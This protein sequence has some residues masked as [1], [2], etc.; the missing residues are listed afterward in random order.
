MSKIIYLTTQL[1]PIINVGMYETNLDPRYL[2]SS[3][4]D[5]LED[6]NL[7]EV[8]FDFPSYKNDIVSAANSILS[9]INDFKK[10]GVLSIKMTKIESPKEYNFSND[11]GVLEV[12]L[13]N[14]FDQQMRKNINIKRAKSNEPWEQ[15]MNIAIQKIWGSR[16]GF[17]SFMPSSIEEIYS[18]SIDDYERA[19]A[20]YLQIMLWEDN[21]EGGIIPP[22]DFHGNRQED[23]N[24]IQMQLIGYC[25]ENLYYSE[26]ATTEHIYSEELWEISQNT[27]NNL[28]TLIWDLFDAGIIKHN[29]IPK[30]ED[31]HIAFLKWCKENE[32]ETEEQLRNLIKEQAA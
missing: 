9:K 2:F 25:E 29:T 11:W 31:E 13:V 19:V 17:W 21:G 3:E 1:L 7:E 27:P 20:Q 18:P 8:D 16:D 10:Y 32:Y 4:I 12:E 28:E 6:E 30:C 14:D 26:Y 5:G 23:D 24:A 22:P 15:K